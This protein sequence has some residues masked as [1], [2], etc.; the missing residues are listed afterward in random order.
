MR[1]ATSRQTGEAEGCWLW[2]NS[3]LVTALDEP[4]A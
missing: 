2:V 4:R 3:L 1:A